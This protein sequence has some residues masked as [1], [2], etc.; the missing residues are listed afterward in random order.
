MGVKT[1]YVPYAGSVE[2]A[3][4]ALMSLSMLIEPDVSTLI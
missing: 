2:A 4:A 3:K 1:F